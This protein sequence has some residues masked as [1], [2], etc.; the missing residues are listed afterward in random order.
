M[1]DLREGDGSQADLI[2]LAN[3]HITNTYPNLSRRSNPTLLNDK[4]Q[5]LIFA[6]LCFY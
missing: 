2:I 3:K 6:K 1:L 4:D 5:K